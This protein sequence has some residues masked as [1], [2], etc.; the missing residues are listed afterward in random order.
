M[1]P[2]C[3]SP[4]PFPTCVQAASL[5][6]NTVFV[7]KVEDHRLCYY[8]EAIKGCAMPDNLS[9]QNG[10]FPVVA[11]GT[12]EFSV[13]GELALDQTFAEDAFTV[14]NHVKTLF[15]KDDMP[16]LDI[17]VDSINATV[18][19]FNSAQPTRVNVITIVQPNVRI[20]N[21]HAKKIVFP[22]GFSPVGVE[23]TNVSIV[24]PIQ[25]APEDDNVD[26]SL[27]NAVFSNVEGNYVALLHHSGIVNS[28]NTEILWLPRATSGD[29]TGVL[30]YGNGSNMNVAKLTGIF[31]AQYQLEQAAGSVVVQ[32]IQANQ[33]ATALLFPTL[34]LAGILVFS[35]SDRIFNNVDKE[36]DGAP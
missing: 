11:N 1:D 10:F 4:V 8:P 9:I 26:V 36:R 19:A 18:R 13:H 24:D 34:L 23:I 33:L 20:H 35:N 27:K 28:T 7:K 3:V 16:D 25:V 5:L 29:E 31:G 14:P 32:N 15:I 6:T 12:E 30:S 17:T 22:E 2:L 21:M